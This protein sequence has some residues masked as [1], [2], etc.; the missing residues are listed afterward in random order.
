MKVLG[1]IPARGGSK[2]VRRKNIVEL[3]SKPLIQYSI[4]SAQESRLTHVVVSSE[5]KEILECARKKGCETIVRPPSL[6]TDFTPMTPVAI[7]ALHQAEK[8]F[9][10]AYEAIMTLQPVA[11]LRAVSD[12]NKAIE[13]LEESNADSVI[14]VVKVLDGHPIRI[15]K[16]EHNRIIPFCFP[17]DEGMRRQDLQPEAFLRNGAIYLTKRESLINGSLHG[18]EQVPLIMPAERSVNI[19]EELDLLIAEAYIKQKQLKGL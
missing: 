6:A 14:S 4:E 1:M 3:A 9:G 19:D 12:I 13:L 5:D 16:I 15:K 2:G 11:P 7:H 18:K 17:E 10:V 8:M